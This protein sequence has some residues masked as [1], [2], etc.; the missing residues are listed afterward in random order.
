LLVWTMSSP[1]ARSAA[2][3]GLLAARERKSRGKA[4]SFGNLS[5]DA[6]ISAMKAFLSPMPA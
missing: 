1:S 3:A 6:R 5:I 2:E 4:G